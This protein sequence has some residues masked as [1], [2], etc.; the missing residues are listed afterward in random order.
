MASMLRPV[1]ALVFALGP[2]AVRA[3]T[4]HEESQPTAVRSEP[5]DPPSP[6]PLLHWEFDCESG[7]IWKVGGGA[8]PLSYVVIPQI[9]TLKSPMVS[10]RSFAGGDLIMRSRFSL[11]LEPII[12]GPEKYYLGASASGCLE[13]WNLKRT[14][15]FFFTSGGGLGVM[16][17][18]GHQIAG[19][20]GQ[21]LNF[22]WL[23]YLGA[24][25][26]WTPQI[27]ASIGVYFQH[28]SNK[29]LDKINPGLNAVGPMLGFSWHY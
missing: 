9:L 8:T 2:I 29:D 27:S 21:D 15:S 13:W 14:T 28:I 19:A 11:L 25:K 5:V 12:R 17:S 20:Q 6:D 18:K 16:H 4:I 1:L 10:R 26:R 7:M 23:A 24:R 22:N 3:Q